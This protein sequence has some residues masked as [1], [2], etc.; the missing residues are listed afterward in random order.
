M[1]WRDGEEIGRANQENFMFRQ[2]SFSNLIVDRYIVFI[3]LRISSNKYISNTQYHIVHQLMIT[4]QWVSL[5]PVQQKRA[6]KGHK[7]AC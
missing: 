6:G 5:L 3:K 4:K 1:G 7:K 2:S